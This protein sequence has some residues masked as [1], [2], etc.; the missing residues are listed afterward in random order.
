MYFWENYHVLRAQ[1]PILYFLES[2]LFSSFLFPVSCPSSLSQLSVSGHSSLFQL[3]VSCFLS[4]FSFLAICFLFLVSPLFSSY[5]FLVT[6]LF[7]RDST[8]IQG[9]RVTTDSES[10]Y[11]EGNVLP[12]NKR[13]NCGEILYGLV[14]NVNNEYSCQFRSIQLYYI[15]K[16]K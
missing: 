9:F 8:N 7:S 14:Q 13:V 3:S 1:F 6:P 15:Y 16:Y 2:L 4:L 11:F 5:L 10:G 12:E